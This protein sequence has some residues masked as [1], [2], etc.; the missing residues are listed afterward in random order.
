MLCDRLQCHGMKDHVVKV[1]KE[2]DFILNK[3]RAEDVK[4][5]ALFEV[6][7]H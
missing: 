1:A 4:K 2:A 5:H 3:Q 6:K 7:L